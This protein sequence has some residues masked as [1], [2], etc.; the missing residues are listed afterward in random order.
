MISIRAGF[1]SL[2]SGAVSGDDASYLRW[3]LL[4]HMPEQY[5]IPGIRLGT[6][7][8]ADERCVQLRA[9]ASP[10]LAPVRHA[11]GYLITDP[12]DVTLTA[13]AA[14]GR[15]LAEAGRYPEPATP[16][17][18]G[19]FELWSAHAAP[20]AVVSA[21]A[22]PFRPHRGIYLVVEEPVGGADLDTW[23]RWHESEHVPAVLS[24]DG[25]AGAFSF[26]ASAALG[27]GPEQ[28]PRYGTA[29]WDPARRLVTV[30]YV[31]GH[32]AATAERLT[33]LVE[34]RWDGGAVTPQLAGPF[35]SP[36]A[37]EAWPDQP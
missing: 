7:W 8:Q 1:F 9:A 26:R 11:V 21:G 4:D 6:R 30:V 5:T 10:P 37:F 28:G 13:F 32:L 23:R 31:D 2:T 34:A 3:H 12:V 15:G 14:L 33:P 22:L 18:L 35:R 36:V 16:H 29:P 20:A 17:L 25:V 19:A 24:V 27:E